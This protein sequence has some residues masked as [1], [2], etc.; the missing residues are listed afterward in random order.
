VSAYAAKPS[1]PPRLTD[2][3]GRRDRLVAGLLGYRLGLWDDDVNPAIE[4]DRARARIHAVQHVK[5]RRRRRKL[6]A[7]GGRQMP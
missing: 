7:V 6:G 5:A 3:T 2:L 4:R 1:I